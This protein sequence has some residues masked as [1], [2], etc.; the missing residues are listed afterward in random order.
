MATYSTMT[1]ATGTHTIAAAYG[2]DVNFSGSSS[3]TVVEII[4]ADAPSVSLT[5]STST[6]AFDGAVTFTGT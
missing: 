3:N 5:A 1:L 2:G 4:Q 6:S